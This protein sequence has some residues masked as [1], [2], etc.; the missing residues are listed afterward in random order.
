MQTL[1][2]EVAAFADRNPNPKT[3]HFDKETGRYT[4]A[5]H[6]SEEPDAERWG[7]LLGDAIHNLRSALDHVIWQLVVLNGEEP[8]AH[9]QWPLCRSREG[10]L[11]PRKK[12]GVSVRETFLRGVAKDARAIIDRLQPYRAG[13]DLDRHFLSSLAPLS[14]ADKHRVIQ[15]GFLGIHE[16]PEGFLARSEDVGEPLEGT[17]TSGPLEAGAYVVDC[18]LAITGPNPQVKM[19]GNLTLVVGFGEEGFALSA[20]GEMALKIGETIELF[21]PLFDAKK[22]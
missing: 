1:H 15:A 9:N 14:N 2:R 16:F 20:I 5:I 7:V 12:G 6:L 13:P 11:K 21:Q 8:G 10:Y 3:E 18:L 19:Q 17:F 4:L 22:P